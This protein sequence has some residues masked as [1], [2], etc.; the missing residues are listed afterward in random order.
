[1]CIKKVL[2]LFC[3]KFKV[4][5]TGNLIEDNRNIESVA[6]FI[7][8]V[9]KEKEL[10]PNKSENFYFRGEK[11]KYPRTIPSLYRDNELILKGSKNY[12]QLLMSW[13]IPTYWIAIP[14]L[15]L[16]LKCNISEQ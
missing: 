4:V 3:D 2:T 15:I 14:N 6:D 12:Y 5:P 7:Q 16:L 11:K 10:E 9:N 8:K 13:D 1:M